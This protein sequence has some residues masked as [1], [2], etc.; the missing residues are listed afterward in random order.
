MVRLDGHANSFFCTFQRT[1]G[2]VLLDL[3]NLLLKRLPF[4]A[5]QLQT[6]KK[7]L[8]SLSRVILHQQSQSAIQVDGGIGGIKL[9]CP[10][11]VPDRFLQLSLEQMSIAPI[12]VG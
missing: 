11:I 12:V 10:A 3:F 4:L 9:N 5:C 8:F 6:L 7:V 2:N 1:T